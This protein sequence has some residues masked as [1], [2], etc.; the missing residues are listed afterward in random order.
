MSAPKVCLVGIDGLRVEDALA[1]P[2]APSLT[3]FAAGGVLTSMRMEVP[4]I[5]G[6]GWTSILT[7]SRHADHGVFDN[8]FHGHRIAGNA[9]LL[10]RAYFADQGI[11]SYAASGWP[12]LTDPAGPGPV[13]AWRE[14]Q[15]RAGRHRVVV[16]DG[17]T[18]GY[19]RA[20]AEVAA[21]SRMVLGQAGPDVSFVYL[22]EVDEAGHCHGGTSRE[23]AEAL[24]R[25]DE[26]LGALL[27]TIRQRTQEHDEDWLVGITTDH[28]HLDEGG[29]GGA[30]D[31]VRRSFFAA[32]R[33]GPHAASGPAELPDRIAPE[34]I[35]PYLLAHLRPS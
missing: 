22:G 33:F 15:Q 30:Q 11:T 20:D 21:F 32:G 23:Y 5:S 13:I 18:Y 29:H 7:A 1:G 16:R 2:D 4:T 25:V 35:V 10:S 34:E 17:E 27:G 19:R 9:D 3:A 12:P 24:R 31:V 14:D 6:P 8:T 28:G 26:H